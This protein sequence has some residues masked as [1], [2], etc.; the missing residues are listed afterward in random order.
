MVRGL[1]APLCHRPLSGEYSCCIS[2]A[3]MYGTPAFRQLVDFKAGRS[4]VEFAFNDD[5][6][7]DGREQSLKE[8]SV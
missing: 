2:C 3:F 5:L 4:S 7:P 6:K 8:Q 1:D